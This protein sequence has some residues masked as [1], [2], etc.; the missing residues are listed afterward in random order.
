MSTL[1]LYRI[2]IPLRNGGDPRRQERRD[3]KA[4]ADVI[5]RHP[6]CAEMLKLHGASGAIYTIAEAHDIED[7]DDLL[8][9]PEYPTQ[10]PTPMVNVDQ[11]WML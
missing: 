7:S 6:F 3:M 11:R 10:K 5:M 9:W 8:I 2:R 1:R 4:L